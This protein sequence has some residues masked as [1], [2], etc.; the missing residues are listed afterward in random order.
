MTTPQQPTNATDDGLIAAAGAF[1][2]RCSYP[3]GQVL[4]TQGE[5][6][7][8]FYVIEAGRMSVTRVD[9]EGQSHL[10]DELGPATYFGEMG[11][12]DDSPRF[13]TVRALTDVTVLEING[14]CFE[15]LVQSHPDL[16]M[17]IVRRVLKSF[18]Q[19]DSRTIDSLRQKNELLEK[20]YYELQAAQAQII[21]KEKL[22]R[23]MELAAEMQRRLLPGILPQVEGLEFA[24]YLAPARAVGGDLYDIRLIDDDHVAVLLADVADKGLK[25]A[26]FMAVARTLFYQQSSL[27]LSPSAVALGVHR[28]L[29]AIGGADDGSYSD[30]FVTAFYGVLNIHTGEM[31]Y[32]RAA[33]DRPLLLRAGHEPLPLPGD[34]RFLGMIEELELEEHSVQ[35]GAGDVLL[36]MSDGIPD[37][38]NPA[39]ETYGQDRLVSLLSRTGPIGAENVLE[40]VLEDI[41]AWSDGTPLFDD[42]TLMALSLQRAGVTTP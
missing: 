11:V 25:A 23:E 31:T 37:A 22:E 42:L 1:G 29:M 9:E 12:L 16:V 21:E 28:G 38:H 30:V 19:L 40:A 33:Q 26:L 4:A 5:V 36:M 10:L 6:E 15:S 39:G 34:G 14:T 41:H 35:L 24:A 27:T 3:A 7:H 20:A 13:A 8:R 32:V 2:R 18:R 17:S